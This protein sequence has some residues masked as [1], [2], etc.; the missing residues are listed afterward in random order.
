MFH[1]VNDSTPE[2]IDVGRRSAPAVADLTGDGHPDIIVGNIAGGLTFFRGIPPPPRTVGIEKTKTTFTNY[3]LIVFPN[4]ASGEVSIIL[5]EQKNG[6][7]TTFR[8][9]D[10]SGR[11][12]KQVNSEYNAIYTLNIQE[13]SNGVYILN[14]EI[15]TARGISG[16]GNTKLIVRNN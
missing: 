2:F 4:P 15:E 11:M 5:P 8:L 16:K 1:M 3:N 12:I 9:Y 13:L 14:A 7:K 6:S 10:L